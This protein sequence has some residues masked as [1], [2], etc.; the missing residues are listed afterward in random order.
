M[1]LVDHRSG[2]R[3]YAVK[4]RH[5]DSYPQFKDKIFIRTLENPLDPPEHVYL[6]SPD[7]LE[8][9]SSLTLDP[10]SDSVIH[11]LSETMIGV[12][13]I[14]KNNGLNSEVLKIFEKISDCIS[15]LPKIS[16][17]TEMIGK[18]NSSESQRSMIR[19]VFT[20]ALVKNLGWNSDVN[21]SKIFLASL[22]CT[23]ESN[24]QTLAKKL[25]DLG[26]NADIVRTVL[27]SQENK[28]GSGPLK[29]KGPYIYNLS[30]IIRV[31]EE[32]TQGIL[33][34]KKPQE[35]AQGLEDKSHLLDRQII[36]ATKGMWD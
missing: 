21:R 27:H 15:T 23:I 16:G 24:P 12:E 8:Y 4:R 33:S 29:I 20:K 25:D 17:L 9:I 32:I 26:L 6:R 35:I 7:Y 2:E 5:L 18:M 1:F 10:S 28:D 11:Q 31:S 3:Y 13:I 34:K 14:L 30:K 22:L 19:T 36:K